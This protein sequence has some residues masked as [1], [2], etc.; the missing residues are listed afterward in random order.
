VAEHL[1]GTYVK[2]NGETLFN[3]LLGDADG[4]PVAGEMTVNN[5]LVETLDPENIIAKVYLSCEE[6]REELITALNEKL[7]YSK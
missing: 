7:N 3:V 5:M 1:G 4:I 6:N 2:Y